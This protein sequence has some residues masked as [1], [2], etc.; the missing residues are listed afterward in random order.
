MSEG[1]VLIVEDETMIL[2][3]LESALEEAGFQ[4]V[5]TRSAA[6]ALAAFDPDPTKFK[7]VLTDIR[8]GAGQSGWEVARHLR[9][10]NSTI[11]V[12]YIS[13][14]SAVHWGAEGVPNSIMITKPFSAADHNCRFST[15]KRAARCRNSP[16]GIGP[17][18]HETTEHSFFGRSAPSGVKR[19]RLLG[20]NVGGLNQMSTSAPFPRHRL[21]Y[22]RKP[23]RKQRRSL[24]E[25]SVEFVKQ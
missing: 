5:G 20:S 21:A 12:V 18:L 6:E 2:L 9:R 3:D 1:A 25:L 13:G 15:F 10:S 22:T 8:L 11:P 19:S 23:S 4:V 17:R 7:A 14:D 16:L 24:V